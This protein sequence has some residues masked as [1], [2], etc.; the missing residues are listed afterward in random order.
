MWEKISLKG[1]FQSIN[2]INIVN[3]DNDYDSCDSTIHQTIIFEDHVYNEHD[4][5]P[6]EEYCVVDDKRYNL[7]LILGKYKAERQSYEAM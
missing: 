5:S 2:S 1:V 7:N 4:E 6:I 3:D